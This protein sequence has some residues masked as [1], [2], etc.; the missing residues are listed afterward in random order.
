MNQWVLDY[1]K[2]DTYQW[3]IEVKE[4]NELIGSIG[5]FPAMDP[6]GASGW[7]VS[8]CIARAP[9]WNKRLCYRA[10]R[11]VLFCSKHRHYRA[12]HACHALGNPASGRVMEKRGLFIKAMAF[13]TASTAVKC[14]AS[15]IF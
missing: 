9:T 13:T 11:A 8:Y 10:L 2:M 5:I 3:A 14:C 12:L 6:P 15:D 7:E 4:N 1:E